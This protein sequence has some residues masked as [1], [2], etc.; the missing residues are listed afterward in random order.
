MNKGRGISKTKN[1]K[2]RT[3]LFN[4][5]YSLTHPIPITPDPLCSHNQTR[6]P[7][8]QRERERERER[9]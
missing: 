5:R 3:P 7:E 1:N 6:N 8:L 4:P 2:T 9:G